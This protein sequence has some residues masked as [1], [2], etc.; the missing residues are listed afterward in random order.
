M[1]NLKPIG[2]PTLDFPGEPVR[3]DLRRHQAQR[4]HRARPCRIPESRLL[5]SPGRRSQDRHPRHRP[6]R[7]STFRFFR[8]AP[9]SPSTSPCP[10]TK[11]LATRLGTITFK[12]NK[13][14]PNSA[15]LRSLFAMKDGEIFSREKVAKGLQNLTQGLRRVR[16]H[17]LHVR[18]QHHVRRR[19]EDRQ[20]GNRRRRRQAVLRSPHRVSGQHHHPR[21]SHPPRDRARRRPGLQL[22]TLGT[23]PAPPEPARL[24]R[25][26]QA[27]RSQHHRPQAGRKG[28]NGRPHAQGHTK[29]ARTR[30]DFRA[31]S[32]A[33]RE[34]LSA[35]PTA[36][37]T[38]SDLGETLS[39]Q[40]SLGNR[41]RDLLFGFTEPYLFDRP[42]Q[43]G[44]TIYTRK[45]NFD[46]ARQLSIQSGQNLNLPSPLLQNL[47][48]Y[49]QSSTGASFSVELSAAPF[50]QANR[51]QLFL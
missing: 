16:L 20:P 50:V 39:V 33:W 29:R 2:I 51:H 28:R 48:N 21:Q 13:A 25:P 17:Q 45:S 11:A 22:A 30:S 8:R 26:A 37:T 35:S 34:P 12:N 40:A 1:K 36:P 15:A 9:A 46:Q 27:R 32:A 31:A 38:F 5:Q 7:A 43:A 19:Q 10:S 23:Q 41:Q 3:Q 44:F 6:C 42:I 49:T 18:P 47:Q 14:I 4:R 24:F